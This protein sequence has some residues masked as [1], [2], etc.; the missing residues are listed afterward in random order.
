MRGAAAPALCQ[1]L[2]LAL[3]PAVSSQLQHSPLAGMNVAYIW[4]SKDVLMMGEWW[5]GKK[6]G[7]PDLS[8]W[9]IRS[10]LSQ[11]SMIQEAKLFL[12]PLGSPLEAWFSAQEDKRFLFQLSIGL[13]LMRLSA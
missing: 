6:G 13:C 10:L 2:L 12:S 1:A 5:Q 9:E 4:Q 11:S 8:G 7:K 3:K